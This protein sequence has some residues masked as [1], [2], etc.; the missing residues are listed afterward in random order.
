MGAFDYK[1]SLYDPE[2]KLFLNFHHNENDPQ[3]FKPWSLR[4]VCVTSDQQVYFGGM[5]EN[6]GLVQLREDGLSFRYFPVVATGDPRGTNDTD[7]QYIYEDS[8][9]ILWLGALNGGLN[10]YDPSTGV[11]RHYV[12]DPQDKTSISN[13]RIKCINI[14]INLF[15]ETKIKP[16]I[17]SYPHRIDNRIT[18]N[19]IFDN[20]PSSITLAASMSYFV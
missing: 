15:Y 9:G 4:S 19:S 2:K 14:Y 12:N 10:R 11:F 6:Q 8:D 18:I 1:I 7:I 17:L 3:A 20:I 16:C 5:G 13:N